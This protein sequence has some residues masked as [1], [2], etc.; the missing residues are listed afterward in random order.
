MAA[1]PVWIFIK[2]LAKITKT[3]V[4]VHITI[5]VYSFF[6]LFGGGGGGGISTIN[7]VSIFDKMFSFFAKY[8]PNRWSNTY[9][10]TA[11][12]NRMILMKKKS[13]DNKKHEK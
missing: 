2:H 11:S 9:L 6:F 13:T 3:C 1:Y 12:A 5:Y 7:M 8:L 10:L 4:L